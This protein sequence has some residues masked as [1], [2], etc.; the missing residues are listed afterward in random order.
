MSRLTAGGIGG[1]ASVLSTC[2]TTRV[3]EVTRDEQGGRM[4]QVLDGMVPDGQRPGSTAGRCRLTDR[5]SP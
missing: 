3:A 2:P 1:T 4:V 5:S